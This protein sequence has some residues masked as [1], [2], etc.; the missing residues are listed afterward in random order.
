V[1]AARNYAHCVAY[2]EV[3]PPQPN[4]GGSNSGESLYCYNPSLEARFD[5]S[6]LPDS[7]P[8]MTKWN[9][10]LVKTPN[11]VGVQ[12]NCMSCHEQ[13]NFNPNNLPAAPDYTGDRYVDLTGAAFKGVLKVEFLWSI[14]D[15]A[16]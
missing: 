7:R 12:T 6:D 14:A 13:A 4:S 10:R 11:D 16:Q 3:S 15:T 9:G 1:G 5:H 8:G 2:H